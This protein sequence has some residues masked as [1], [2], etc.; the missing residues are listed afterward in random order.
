MSLVS[1]FGFTNVSA[2]THTVTP[3]NLSVM[4][5]YALTM[6]EPN[7]TDLDNKTCPLDQP[8]RLSFKCQ[9]V[10]KVSTTLEL[11][12][13]A[14]VTTGI[15]YVVKLDEV[16]RT[17]STEDPTFVVDEPV[18]AYITIRHQRSSNITSDHVAE[19][20]NRLIGACQKEDGSWRFDD[21]MRSAL[22]P[23]EN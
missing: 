2:S 3:K 12:H 23:T 22:K 5:N 20:F 16:L 18:V 15:Q 1:K 9:K 19:I 10:N 7:E 21:L 4:T 13:P 11:Q 14:P 17:T 8:E 6:D